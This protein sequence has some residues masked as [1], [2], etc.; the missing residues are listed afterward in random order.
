MHEMIEAQFNSKLDMILM[1]Y[2]ELLTQQLA[3]QRLYFE[4]KLKEL[5]K[6]KDMQIESLLGELVAF[7]QVS[8]HVFIFNYCNHKGEAKDEQQDGKKSKPN[9]KTE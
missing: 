2:N 8:Q 7:R 9:A 6:E 1:E 4:G 5:E 3:S